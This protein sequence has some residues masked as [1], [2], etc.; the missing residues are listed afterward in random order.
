[1][2][3]LVIV[4]DQ[5]AIPLDASGEFLLWQSYADNESFFS[6]P[7]YLEDHAE[8]LRVKYLAFI[9]DLGERKIK[10]KR[11][12]EHLDM[13]EGF[14]FWWMTKLA[15]K[16]PFKSPKIYD[17][18]RLMA[19]EEILV[20]RR[21]VRLDLKSSDRDLAH[22]IRSLCQSL[23]IGFSWEL[24]G[25]KKVSW[26]LR[27]L[28]RNLPH[29][30][31]GLI[32]FLWHVF[33]RWP[34]R[35]VQKQKWFPTESGI[36][37]GSYFIH[38]DQAAMK[39]GRFYSRHW[40]Q[41]PALLH[42]R[43]FQINW[44]QHFLVSSV[45]PD[46]KTGVDSLASFN[47][48]PE[49][50]G[51]HTFLDSY[52]TPRIV[53]RALTRW[54]RL[55]LVAWRVRHFGACFYPSE[56][57]VWLWPILRDDWL[58]SI[59]GSTASINCLWFEL[60]DV[61]M[62]D[63]PPQKNG[64]YLC[65]NQGWERAFLH[66]WRKHGH[67]H[68]IGV[69]HATVPFWHLYYFDD[70]RT[71]NSK[72]S[73]RMPLPDRLAVNGPV[74]RDAFVSSGYAIEQLAEVEALRYL[75]LLGIASKHHSA[76]SEP[77]LLPESSPSEIEK[78]SVLI[79]G[80][81]ISKSNHNL[82]SLMERAVRS[83]SDNYKFTFKPHPGLQVDLSNYPGIQAEQTSE[84]LDRILSEFDMAVSANSTSAAVDAFLAGLPVIIGLDGSSFNLSPLRGQPGVRF[85][86]T[87]VEMVSALTN[88]IWANSNSSE[89]DLFW[90]Q[91]ELPRWHH[92][93]ANIGN[94]KIVI[95]TDSE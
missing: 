34:L 16:S 85:V 31:Q 88:R 70:P 32:V 8:R 51:L 40:E 91:A 10:G 56:S 46:E 27:Q 82:L 36:F 87:T 30:T 24:A 72:A 52:L 53:V 38:L 92:L 79:L 2:T 35:A 37:M 74:A 44:L 42:G 54:M 48:D 75:N 9:H 17:C 33:S 23:N 26:S 60:F 13:G 55:N 89:Q 25:D 39:Q 78:V 71:I 3:S 90:L 29:S 6:I 22:A 11:I 21:P 58:S 7:R 62:R 64:F 45:V 5:A 50:Q 14:S 83:L 61:A 84:K 69:V 41:L 67:G 76:N 93:L 19:L 1:M 81:M 47:R 18:L 80:D 49:N 15:E 57:A 66:A 59:V 20:E 12:V 43:G 63:I 95:A 68:V 28:Y 86:G 73:C 94:S 65:E 77:R 4:W